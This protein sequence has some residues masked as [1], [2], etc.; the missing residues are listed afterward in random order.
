MS[1]R[2]LWRGP[3]TDRE[4]SW[5]ANPVF[6]RCPVKASRQLMYRSVLNCTLPESACM[7]HNHAGYHDSQHARFRPVEMNTKRLA[8][9]EYAVEP[10]AVGPTF[11]ACSEN[12]RDRCLSL[13]R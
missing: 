4:S 10:D 5:P 2:V 7:S 8:R 1:T 13:R 12:H 11:N 9:P 3:T 6:V